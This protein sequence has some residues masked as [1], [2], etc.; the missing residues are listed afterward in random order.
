MP[1]R[2][3]DVLE[4]MLHQDVHRP[5]DDN[6]WLMC[7]F[8][9]SRDNLSTFFRMVNVSNILYSG[10]SVLCFNITSDTEIT[11]YFSEAFIHHCL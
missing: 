4:L 11:D 5:Y 6:K 10:M 3:L 2:K 9:F 1:T 8:Q 7:L